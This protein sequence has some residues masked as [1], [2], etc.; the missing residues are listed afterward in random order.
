MDFNQ[1]INAI[2]DV[3]SKQNIDI[4]YDL[5]DG[6]IVKILKSSNTLDLGRTTNQTHIAITG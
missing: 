3:L 4:N 1:A 5:Y 2:K 6:L